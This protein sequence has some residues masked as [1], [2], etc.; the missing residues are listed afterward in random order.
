MKNDRPYAG[1]VVNVTLPLRARISRDEAER[2]LTARWHEQCT[3]FPTMRD[4]I[5]LK[6]YLEVNAPIV[7]IF[8]QLQDY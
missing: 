6:R 2:R 3:L 5:P 1:L 8:D 4:D 7:M